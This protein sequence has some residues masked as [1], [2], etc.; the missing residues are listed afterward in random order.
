MMSFTDFSYSIETTAVPAVL[1]NQFL[2]LIDNFFSAH[3]VLRFF[4]TANVM[5]KIKSAKLFLCIYYL[6]H[7]H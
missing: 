2:E 7:K 3:N 6:I 1:L 5:K 4:V